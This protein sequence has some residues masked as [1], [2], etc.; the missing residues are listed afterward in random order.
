MSA[1]RIRLLDLNQPFEFQEAL[2]SAAERSRLTKN[3]TTHQ[4]FEWEPQR[5]EIKE[6]RLR[7]ISIR[8]RTINNASDS[9]ASLPD[10]TPLTEVS[11]Y[12]SRDRQFVRGPYS[13]VKLLMSGVAPDHSPH[14]R[15]PY[16]SATSFGQEARNHLDKALSTLGNFIAEVEKGG[17]V[18]RIYLSSLLP[19]GPVAGKFGR[20]VQVAREDLE[21]LRHAF[22]RLEALKL[23]IP[24]NPKPPEHPEPPRPPVNWWE[25]MPPPNMAPPIARDED[26][27]LI[28][29]VM[30]KARQV[31]CELEAQVFAPG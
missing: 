6:F 14:M 9:G 24:E 23:D 22:T 21:F 30:G 4:L 2:L 20:M 28:D 13:A 26:K 7:S 29:A 3:V 1:T 8:L 19:E 5:A 18:Q 10:G 15:N 12:G 16:I 27:L 25:E 17:R 11:I 31:L